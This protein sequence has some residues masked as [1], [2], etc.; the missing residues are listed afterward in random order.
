[1]ACHS[2]HCFLGSLHAQAAA[3]AVVWQLR[4]QHVLPRQTLRKLLGAVKTF[5]YHW[6][7]AFRTMWSRRSQQDAHELLRT[8]LAALAD[9]RE[10]TQP[11]TVGD[12]P[13]PLAIIGA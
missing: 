9:E 13:E 7:I 11:C 4:F 2:A 12:T 6:A 10:D 3:G 1:M 5:T 8:L